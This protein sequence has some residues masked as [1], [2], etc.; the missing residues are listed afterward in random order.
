MNE[1][2]VLAASVLW[3]RD[4]P[5]LY[6]VMLDQLIF[7]FITP[8]N[9]LPLHVLFSCCPKATNSQEVHKQNTL[10]MTFCW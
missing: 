9:G 6:P 3:R 1:A 8:N 4:S 10:E 5:P 2:A 7:L